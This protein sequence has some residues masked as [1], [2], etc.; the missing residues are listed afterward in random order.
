MVLRLVMGMDPGIDVD[1]AFESVDHISEVGIENGVTNEQ[2][3]GPL[4]ID[5]L[6]PVQPPALALRVQ[7]LLF[8]AFACSPRQFGSERRHW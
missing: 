8:L 7:T 5:V 6:R 1:F 2:D 4:L 3:A